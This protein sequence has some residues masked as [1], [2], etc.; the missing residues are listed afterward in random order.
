MSDVAFVIR[1]ASR[2]AVRNR[3]KVIKD[4]YIDVVV[5]ELISKKK[6]KQEQR[7]IGF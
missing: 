5:K 2:I 4:E 1:E 6:D 3:S 7:K